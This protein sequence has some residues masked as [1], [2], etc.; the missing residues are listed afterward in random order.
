M[1]TAEFEEFTF[2]IDSIQKMNY[3]QS[4]NFIF[5][6]KT[7]RMQLGLKE[8]ERLILLMILTLF[9]PFIPR[10]LSIIHAFNI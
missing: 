7:N 9:S 10:N 3:Q 6:L 1:Q 8:I 4:L 5:R 2:V